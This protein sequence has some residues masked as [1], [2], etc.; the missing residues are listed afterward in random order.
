L[1]Q[2]VTTATQLKIKNLKEKEYV[3]ER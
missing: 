2:I 3:S 1:A